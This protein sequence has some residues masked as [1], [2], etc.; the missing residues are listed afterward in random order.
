MGA[1]AGFTAFGWALLPAIRHSR[2]LAAI[3]A[4]AWLCLGGYVSTVDNRPWPG[5]LIGPWLLATVVVVVLIALPAMGK[6]PERPAAPGRDPPHS[7][8]GASGQAPTDLDL[9]KAP[10]D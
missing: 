9:P 6:P 10:N 5:W 3:A 7:P 8:G 2:A 1:F 4:V